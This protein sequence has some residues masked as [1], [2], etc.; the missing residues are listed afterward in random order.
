LPLKNVAQILEIFDISSLK[1][2]DIT[3]KSTLLRERVRRSGGGWRAFCKR[4]TADRQF[5]RAKLL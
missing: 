2:T 1:Q 4:R 3:T 5:S